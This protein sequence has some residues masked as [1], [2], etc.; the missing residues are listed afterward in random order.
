[1]EDE[2]KDTTES[3]APEPTE[4]PVSEPSEPTPEVTERQ[5][6]Y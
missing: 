3:P 4:T 5:H 2:T 1:M 6:R